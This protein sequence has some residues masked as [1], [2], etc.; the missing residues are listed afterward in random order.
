MRLIRVCVDHRIG[1]I[2]RTPV[3]LEY[4]FIFVEIF[5]LWR[6]AVDLIACLLAFAASDTDRRIDK[7]TISIF[8]QGRIDPLFG[9]GIYRQKSC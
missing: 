3:D 4:G 8:S 6:Q 5:W 1:C 2:R 7:H 9:D